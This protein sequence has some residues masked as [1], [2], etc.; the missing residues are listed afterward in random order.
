MHRP[1]LPVSL[2]LVASLVS[3][4]RLAPA[5]AKVN[6]A[7]SEA[8][9]PQPELVTR[10]GE[11]V[12]VFAEHPHV[13]AGTPATFMVH[14]SVLGTGEPVRAG[15]AKVRVGKSEFR[16]ESPSAPGI[17]P[18]VVTPDATGRFPLVIA[19]ESEQVS[20]AVECGELYVHPNAGAAE[21]AAAVVEPVIASNQ[22]PFTFQQ[23][24]PLRLLLAKV[25]RKELARRLVVPASVRLP[26]GASADVHAPVG[27]RLV[28]VEGRALPRSG[29]RVKAGEVLCSVEPPVDAA[30]VA[31]LHALRL[32]LEMQLVEAV[33]EVEHSKLRR[34]FAQREL[35][36]LKTLR[37]DGL[38]TLP[39]LDAAE[40]DVEM[41]IHEEELALGRKQTVERLIADRAPFD[42]QS[43]SPVVRLPVLAPIDGVVTWAP[44]SAGTNVTP[45]TELLRIV[46]T[47]RVWLEGRVSEFDLH[48][49]S[50]ELGATATILGLPGERMEL[51]GAP[52]ITPRV[53]EESRAVLVRFATENPAGKLIEGQL[54]E[55]EL[56]TEIV[57]GALSIPHE[58]LV[59]DQGVPTAYVM[60]SGELFEK[61]QL[62]LGV[63]DGASVEVLEGLA[64]GE[65]VVTRGAYIVRLASMSPASMEHHHH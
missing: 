64:E 36:R 51:T 60:R 2:F 31:Q 16:L 27:G 56:R 1:F 22:V 26:D 58:A 25:E 65:R 63:R 35:D 28:P 14:L 55:L 45:D 8:P 17:F 5:S 21:A 37:P 54:A 19:I 52:W 30:T 23:Q 6:A 39:E 20:E 41:T 9:E 57:R 13:A 46:D 7:A 48:R 43:G 59:M 12:L 32:E 42:P 50:R 61:R 47:S 44:H 33:H 62:R 18:V 29:E 53:S 38:S 3:C 4:D 24:W 40:L 10:F 11:R 49:V 34:S 15:V